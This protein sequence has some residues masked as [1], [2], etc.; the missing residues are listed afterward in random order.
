MSADRQTVLFDAATFV[1]EQ[2]DSLPP[3]L[4]AAM[5]IGIVGF[6]ILVRLRYFRAYCDLS[7][8]QRR[9]VATWCAYGPSMVARQMFRALRSTAL[10]AYY[11]HPLTMAASAPRERA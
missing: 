6:R 11:E 9:R 2:T 8:A 4:R 10:L 1:R 3:Q 7:L 5:R